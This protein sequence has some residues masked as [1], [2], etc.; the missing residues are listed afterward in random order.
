MDSEQKALSLLGLARKAGK[1]AAGEFSTEKAVKGG[2][3]FMVFISTDASENTKKKF[4]NMCEWHKVPIICMADMEK[5]GRSIGCGDR[6]SLAVLD[7]G[8]AKAIE[9]AFGTDADTER[10]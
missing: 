7:Q 5:L 1:I 4:R 8:F 6:S 2:A 3:A 10:R 9:K